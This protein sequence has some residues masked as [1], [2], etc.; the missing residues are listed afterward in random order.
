MLLVKWEDDQMGW[1][2]LPLT[3]GIPA[4]KAHV[5]LPPPY[6]LICNMSVGGSLQRS[7]CPVH[8]HGVCLVTIFSKSFWVKSPYIF[9]EARK[10]HTIFKK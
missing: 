1:G 4:S 5:S 2:V 3:C 8:W 6:I 10:G 7:F 9:E